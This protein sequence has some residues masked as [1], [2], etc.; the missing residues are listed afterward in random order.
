M[1]LRCANGMSVSHAWFLSLDAW[2]I[3]TRVSQALFGCSMANSRRI[4]ISSHFLILSIQLKYLSKKERKHLHFSLE[5]GAEFPFTTDRSI[6]EGHHP[7]G[8]RGSRVV[9]R[10]FVYHV[11]GEGLNSPR[12]EYFFF[13][14][15]YFTHFY[16]PRQSQIA[17]L[18]KKRDSVTVITKSCSQ[19]QYDQ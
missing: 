11:I 13:S 5:P 1:I 6:Y 10:E 15:L 2:N 9:E 17:S 3:S 8:W 19:Q 4:K 14:I 7:F 12:W 18:L 16:W